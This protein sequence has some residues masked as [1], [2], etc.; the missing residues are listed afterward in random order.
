MSRFKRLIVEVHHRSLWQVLLIY[1]VASWVVFEVVQTVTEGLGLPPWFPAFAA[2]LLLV[3]LPLVLATAFVQEGGPATGRSDPT[4]LPHADGTADTD[5]TREGARRLLTWRNALAGGV[6]ALALWGVVATAWYA[7]YGGAAALEA[8]DR[9]S[10]AVLPF[11]NVGGD[12]E[13]EYFSDG[14]TGDIIAH[15]SK[16]ADLKVISRTSVMQYKSTEK[17]LPEIGEELGVAT[18]LEGEVQ[19]AGDRIRINAQLI[20]AESDDHLWAEQYDRQLTDVFA[21][22]SDVARQIATALKLTLTPGEKGQLEKQPTDNLE[23]YEYY[24]RGTAH[25]RRRQLERENDLAVRMYETA[26]DLDPDFAEAW[27]ELAR[28]RVRL[29]FVYGRTSELPLARAAVDRAM[30]L[31]PELSETRMAV[32]DY[33]YYGQRDYA[34]ALEHYT[35]VQQE[36]PNNAQALA[37]IGWIRRRQGKWEEAVAGLEAALELDPRHD[38]YLFTLG[39]THLLRRRYPEAERYFNRAMSFAPDIPGA[40]LGK[41]WLDLSRDGDIEGARQVLRKASETIDP[42]ELLLSAEL[43]R[44]PIPL[45][46]VRIFPGYYA[47]V[48]DDRLVATLGHDSAFY[49][50]IRA[51]LSATRGETGLARGNYESARAVLEARVQEW[52]NEYRPHALLGLAYAGLGRTRDAILHG[53]KA[54]ALLPVSKDARMGPSLVWNLAEIAVMVGEYDAAID[55]LEYLL[56]IPSEMSIPLLRIDPI[57]DPLRDHP[58]FQELLG[59]V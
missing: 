4:L 49:L 22:Q 9:K 8:V 58:R 42:A 52:P 40:Y 45:A 35:F 13:N 16:I 28:V 15:L 30:A 32:G 51:E 37:S 33:Y 43:G 41:T 46:L 27:A 48:L 50:L 18:I 57:W 17:N 54:A 6:L 23:A 44:T 20:D 1:A 39:E 2:L 5:R 26:V 29:Y 59:G 19:R 47:Q 14:I 3:G 31:A 56:S 11:A 12:P 25:F 21:I 7:L 53:E 36:Q 24:L 34:R 55:H 10:V 38:T